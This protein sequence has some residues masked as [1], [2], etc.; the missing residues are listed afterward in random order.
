MVD[1][2][3]DRFRYLQTDR[4]SDSFRERFRERQIDSE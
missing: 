1:S 3:H 4:E 2:D